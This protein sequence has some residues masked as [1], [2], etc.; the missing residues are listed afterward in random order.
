LHDGSYSLCLLGHNRCIENNS[1]GTGKLPG[2]D[3]SAV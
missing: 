2:G 3:R 1:D